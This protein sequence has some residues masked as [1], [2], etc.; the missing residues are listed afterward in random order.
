[1]LV[2]GSTADK[3][4]RLVARSEAVEVLGEGPRFVGRGGEKL[5]SALERFSIPVEGRVALDAGASTGGFT[6][7]LLQRGARRVYAVDVGQG[8]LAVKLARD[9]RVVVVDR[10][11]VRELSAAR[12]SRPGRP[13]DGAGVVA[14]DLSFISLRT[15]LPALLPLLD[16]DGDLVTLVKPQFEA[17][18]Q[19]V[20]RGRGVIRDPEVWRETVEGVTSALSSLGAVIMG[21][22]PSPITGAAGNVEFL[23]HAVRGPD[24]GP[25]PARMIAS[26]LAEA[27]SITR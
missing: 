16:R 1:V 7:C 8:Q 24:V 11:N 20:S 18:R 15:A 27:R 22:V 14:V 4:S 5:A 23:L 10:T 3:P 19:V 12:L 13:F 9:A 26:A 21:V 2:A 25:G 6:D 17:G